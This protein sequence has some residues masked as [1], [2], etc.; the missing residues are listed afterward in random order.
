VAAVR[1]GLVL[2]VAGPV[3]IDTGNWL[4]FGH[5]LLGTDVRSSTIVY[6]PVVPVLAVT[7][8][9]V[10][11]VEVGTALLVAVTSVL[12]AAGCAVVLRRAGLVWEALPLVAL[13]ALAGSSGEAAAWG[14]FP[15]L[16]GFGLLAPTVWLLD[17]HLR[18]GG[19]RSGLAVG[20]LVFAVVATSHFVATVLAVAGTVLVG[21]HLV[22][23]PG[24]RQP[25]PRR[26]AHLVLGLAPSLL[27]IPQYVALV[28]VGRSAA[29]ND[30]ARP[31]TDLPGAIDY[32]VRDLR[33]LWWAVGVAVLAIPVVLYDRRRSR[34]WLVSTA[35]TVALVTLFA[36]LRDERVVYGLPLAGALAVGLLLHEGVGPRGTSVVTATVRRRRVVVSVAATAL[37]VAQAVAG[38]R[39]FDD[40][41]RYYAV[42]GGG[43]GDAVVW[44]RHDTEPGTLVAVAPVRAAPVGWW[45]EGAGR[46]PALV[47]SALRWLSFPDERERARVA[48]AIFGR[49][50]PTADQLALAEASGV[51][52]LL[53][54][55]AWSGYARDALHDAVERGAVSIRY[56]N[57]DVVVLGT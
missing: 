56:E 8:T 15:Q 47:A 7:V 17:R 29:T 37:V 20:G 41:L 5:D 27:F 38:A 52:L 18:I 39:L 31:L 45:V 33:P 22:L 36:L 1:F 51:D 25:P 55:K 3:T 48:N 43:V 19:L 16:V 54:P 4:A 28:E 11:G 2:R 32:V 42:A 24:G 10:L 30:G 26:F 12:P 53:V 6:P 14:G 40:Q 57:A 9:E 49:D 21:A 46:R 50:F 44:L 34:L 13:V 35:V 23:R